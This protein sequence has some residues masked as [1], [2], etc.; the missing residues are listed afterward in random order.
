MTSKMSVASFVKELQTCF[1]GYWRYPEVVDYYYLVN[2]YFRRVNLLRSSR[3]P[4]MISLLSI[5]LG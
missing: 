1:G 5:R 4:F 3:T 2:P